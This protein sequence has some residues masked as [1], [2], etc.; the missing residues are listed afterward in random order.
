M[1]QFSVWSSQH[2]VEYNTGKHRGNPTVLLRKQ[3]WHTRLVL[4]LRYFNRKHPT[5]S[6]PMHDAGDDTQGQLQESTEMWLL[7]YILGTGLQVAC[8][9]KGPHWIRL[10]PASWIL[11]FP[12]RI[13]KRK[14]EK[15]KGESKWIIKSIML[16]LNT[17][18]WL[19][20]RNQ[21]KEADCT[22]F[23]L[24]TQ[25]SRS[26]LSAE[27]I[28]APEKTWLG[29]INALPSLNSER[30]AG[31]QLKLCPPLHSPARLVTSVCLHASE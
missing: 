16:G 3:S 21:Q 29:I 19:F 20:K 24:L 5:P 28:E 27:L 17:S 10:A 30:S 13:Q 9:S 26:R 7:E 8:P 12:K 22:G 1:A 25:L 14:R 11:Q 23:R 2:R 6:L 4:R 15:G 18:I 31:P